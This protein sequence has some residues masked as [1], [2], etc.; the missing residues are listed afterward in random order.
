MQISD[1]EKQGLTHL[2]QSPDWKIVE[3]LIEMICDE[4]DQS[5]RVGESQ[6]DTIVNA[7]G[8]DYQKRGMRTL[9]QKIYEI[10]GR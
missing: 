10:A 9:V 2:L 8:S 7:I 4:I 1:R 6:W 5:P 3:H